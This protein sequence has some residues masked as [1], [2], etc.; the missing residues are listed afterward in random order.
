MIFSQKRGWPLFFNFL[1]WTPFW[2]FPLAGTMFR[3]PL[4]YSLANAGAR[5]LAGLLVSAGLAGA[6]ELCGTR[7]RW[8]FLIAGL[9]CWIGAQVWTLF[10]FGSTDAINTFTIATVGQF[11]AEAGNIYIDPRCVL[12]L[13][14]ATL[15]FL[16]LGRSWRKLDWAM[17]PAR[18]ALGLALALSLLPLDLLNRY[19]QGMGDD[20]HT[21]T[22]LY[23][24]D[25]FAP[26]DSYYEFFRYLRQLAELRGYRS[27]HPLVSRDHDEPLTLI[28]MVG[29]STARARMSLYGY[30][31]DT[32]PLARRRMPE[33]TV[34]DNLI[35]NFPLTLFALYHAFAL[36][37]VPTARGAERS[38]LFNLL[39]SA[40]FH[41]EWVSNQY[42]YGGPSDVLTTLMSA[43]QTQIW[44]QDLPQTAGLYSD[45][46]LLPWIAR[47]IA[48][49]AP[50]S[51]VFFHMIGT[52]FPYRGHFPEHFARPW[53]A[54]ASPRTAAQR[55]FIDDYDTALRYQDDM[56]AQA[57]RLAEAQGES[58]NIALVYFSDHGEEVYDQ[59]PIVLHAYPSATRHMVE[60]PLTIWLSPG[61][62]R[63]RP[64]LA[65]AV[66]AA[67]HHPLQTRDLA[68]LLLDL[69]SVKT[70][71]D[72]LQHP[73]APDFREGP[74][75]VG[76][77]DY[78]RDPDLGRKPVLLP[79]CR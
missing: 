46:I 22:P 50:R 33:L 39:A 7:R 75:L 25:L 54:P 69:A 18:A 40:G 4:N 5:V 53:P 63:A 1:F 21:Q 34:F 41:T 76:I 59:Y 43:T 6:A 3:P 17:V 42:R 77:H 57:M 27:Q 67:R 74:R 28:V 44:A 48:D 70:A 47:A 9:A 13:A 37:A 24:I 61:L 49:P 26:G 19:R 62:R 72:T 8:F 71:G 10:L 15:P 11:L 66:E 78:D 68:P 2:L 14:G 23:R 38:T 36:P 52:H 32:T 79:L 31:R 16:L 60:V 45:H 73:L 20:G 64:D 65:R 29:E 58:H 30:C 35:S 12:P 51:A 55:R 56:L